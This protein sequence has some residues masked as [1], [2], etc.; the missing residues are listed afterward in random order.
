MCLFPGV[1]P[2][3]LVKAVHTAAKLAVQKVQEL[4]VKIESKSPEEQKLVPSYRKLASL[5]NKSR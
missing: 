2:R 5:Q 4:A 1:H 3:I